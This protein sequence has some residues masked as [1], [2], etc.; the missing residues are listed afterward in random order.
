[1]LTSDTFTS[2]DISRILQ[3]KTTTTE[4]AIALFDQ[5]E[6]V[7]LDFMMGRW[8]GA[9]I[10]TGHPMDGM[11]EV[12]NWYGKEFV[13][14]DCVHPLL[15]L[16]GDRNLFKISPN[17]QIMKFALR[18]PALKSESLKPAFTL[19]NS[20]FKTE[21]SQARLRMMEHRGKL[22]A[23]MIYDH[24]PINDVFRKIDENTVFGLMDYKESAQ[25]FFFTLKRES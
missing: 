9:G 2:D 1:M 21:K 14:A 12:A 25:P 22:S 16:D 15:L 20:L 17:P 3:Q 8:Q 19:L 4:E 6:P 11:L 7:S 5:L 13:S 23:T 18:L 24:L 10:N